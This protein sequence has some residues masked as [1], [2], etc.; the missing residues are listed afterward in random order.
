MIDEWLN[1]VH[2][3]DN[4][5]LLDQ[6]PDVCVDL[7]YIDPPF[8]SGRDYGEF[9]DKYVSMEAYI[10]FMKARCEQLRRV[11]KPTGSF[12]CHCDPTA[13]HYVK[14]MLDGLFS[15]KNFRSEIIWERNSAHNSARKYGA[16]HDTIL[17][18]TK[19]EMYVW[20]KIYNKLSDEVINDWYVHIEPET[21]RRYKLEILT[22]PEI[23][24]GRS[25]EPWRGIDPK[26]KRRHWAIPGF[27]GEI[28]K[29]LGTQDALDVLEKAGRICWPKRK[30]GFPTIKRYLSESKG[31]CQQ[32]VIR[33]IKVLGRMS[34]ERNK[35]PTQKPLALLERIIRSSSNEGD[36]VLDAFCG[37]GTT[38]VAAA[39]TGRKWIGMDRSDEAIRIARKRLK[40]A[41]TRQ[42]TLF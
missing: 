27:V 31:V 7:V 13:S 40:K 36:I 15:I 25:C 20:N 26:S 17:F 1:K 3:G 28:V 21:G 6:L 32:D 2:Q 12:Y 16:I 30:G 41:Q 29:G 35:Y 22:G 18:Y 19:S 38:L 14:V 24:N 4:L 23:C 11:L 42:L 8:H 33:D 37:S 39:Q 10:D 9:S 5:E 34:S